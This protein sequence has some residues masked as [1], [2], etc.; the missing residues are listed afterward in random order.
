M[1]STAPCNIAVRGVEA[2]ASNLQ[3]SG[4]H[5]NSPHPAWQAFYNQKNK[6]NSLLCPSAQPISRCLRL[7]FLTDNVGFPQPLHWGG[8]N[9]AAIWVSNFSPQVAEFQKPEWD[10][11]LGDFSP[12]SRL[13]LLCIFSDW[14]FKV[15]SL[16]EFV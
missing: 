5:L 4:V 3:A 10:L 12:I 8:G 1:L 13:I 11:I 14:A 2:E 16:M 6:K 9:A 15:Q 7:H